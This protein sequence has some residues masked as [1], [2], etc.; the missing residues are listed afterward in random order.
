MEYIGICANERRDIF[1]SPDQYPSHSHNSYEIL[2]PLSTPCRFE[3]QKKRFTSSPLSVIIFPPGITHRLMAEYSKQLHYLYLQFTPE[4]IPD[5]P[6]IKNAISEL[7][8]AS[9]DGNMLTLPAQSFDLAVAAVRLLCGAEGEDIHEYFFSLLYVCIREILKAGKALPCGPVAD[10]IP[11]TGPSLTDRIIEY[12]GE[13][14][15]TV[16]DLSFVTEVFHYSTVHANALFRKRLGVSLWHY[17]LHVRMDRASDLLISGH[18][19][20]DVMA[21]CGFGDYSTFYRIFKKCYGVTPSE[22]KKSGKK[23][24][25]IY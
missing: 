9:K 12:V 11:D 25:L 5:D 6:K 16:R 8:D 13:N 23:P 10:N 17:V 14:Y 18:S 4:A 22:C 3:T 24:E 15:A 20:E 1:P 19:A 2:L 7:F 21:R